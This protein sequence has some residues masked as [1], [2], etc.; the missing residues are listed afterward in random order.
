[1]T[2]KAIVIRKD[3]GGYRAEQE[4]VAESALP[5]GD[6]LV[7]VA[8]SSINYKDALAISGKAP[9]VR[10]FP[11]VAGI[12]FAGTVRESRSDR[13]KPGDKVIL[14]GWGVGETHWGG[15]AGAARVSADWLVPLPNALT[16][17]QAM[18]IGT[19][20]YTAML[21]VLTLEEHGVGKDGEI[22]VTGATGGVGSVALSL[23]AQ[24]GCK[25]VVSSGKS[26]EADYLKR[27]GAAEVIDRSV[28]SKPGKPL[29]KERWSG[30]VDTVGGFTLA[31]AC[32]ATRYGGI[33]AACGMA[34]SL[35]L[36]ASVAPFILRGV[37]LAGVDSVYCP[38][39]KRLKAW[40]RLAEQVDALQLDTIATTI[41]LGEVI[42]T[43]ADILAARIRGRIV[44]DVH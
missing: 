13:F 5:E 27:L 3:D 43:A 42:G 25:V 37:T 16:T 28:L 20:G 33:V 30:V 8:H 24:Q 18:A 39:P 2:F 38:M 41:R 10:S 11:M 6:V 19:A 36:P 40:Q 9:V 29:A 32:A 12:D 34:E 35:D 4:Q 44:V 22:L 26:H 23:L 7:D 31:N 21:C 1:M 15:L 17:W 14:N